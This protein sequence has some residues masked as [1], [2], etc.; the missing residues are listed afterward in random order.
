MTNRSE[1]DIEKRL[2]ALEQRVFDVD[3]GGIGSPDEVT[4]G[5]H[6]HGGETLT[7]AEIVLDTII[8]ADDGTAYDVGDELVRSGDVSNPLT[9]DLDAG[10]NSLTNVAAAEVGSATINDTTEN[11]PR[12]LI[13]YIE[14]EEVGSLSKTITGLDATLLDRQYI[15]EVLRYEDRDGSVSQPLK[16]SLSGTDAGS[17]DYLQQ[18]DT[19][20]YSRITGA[21][22]YELITTPAKD[23]YAA[24]IYSYIPVK[25]GSGAL[26]GDG[27]EGRRSGTQHL[28]KSTNDGSGA[29]PDDSF[30]VTFSAGQE[31]SENV[32]LQAAVFE[33][34]R[35]SQI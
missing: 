23:S 33:T 11:D 13:G 15:I 29:A 8:D 14:E 6:Q 31:G 30:D 21:D 7:P 9:G 19:G 1:T 10:G 4:Y 26:F 17:I 3:S 5:P 12:E 22:A 25:F 32:T 2:I 16:L 18:D 28:I 34:Q 27:A 24:G 35:R 20:T